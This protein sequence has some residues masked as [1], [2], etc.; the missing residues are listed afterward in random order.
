MAKT[1]GIYRIFCVDSEKSYV[2]SAVNIEARW[3]LHRHD[4]R[5][6]KHHSTHLQRAW[7]KYGEKAFSF[8]IIE[9]VTE[10]ESLVQ[11]EQFHLDRF[12]AH[13]AGYNNA[14]RAGSN[15]GAK[16]RMVKQRG[17][18]R[19]E[20]KRKMSAS[21][22]GIKPAPEVT[23]AIHE[24]LHQKRDITG[25]R[26]KRLVVLSYAGPKKIGNHGSTSSS[27]DC[28]CDCGNKVFGVIRANLLRGTSG[29][30]GCLQRESVAHPMPPEV[31]R[32]L[33]IAN[34]G[35]IVSDETKDRIRKSLFGVKHSEARRR[36]NSEGQLRHS[37]KNTGASDVR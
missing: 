30:C 36:A 20:S 28:Q 5:Q 29:S 33:S 23:K 14:P 31:K 18:H 26:F 12:N 13:H 25:M 37:H 32:K 2:G 11:R 6:K 24:K 21:K 35:R 16:Y 17:P 19:E 15:L 22:M 34:M 8:E 27:W 3:R 7:D 4:L 1:S 9:E 10:L